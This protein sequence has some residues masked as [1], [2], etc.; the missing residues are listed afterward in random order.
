MSTAQDLTALGLLAD[1]ERDYAE[2]DKKWSE[3][4]AERSRVK[5]AIAVIREKVA[6]FPVNEPAAQI[7]QAKPEASGPAEIPPDAFA[8]MKIREAARKYMEM[9][10]KPVR[11]AKLARALNKGG[12][13]NKTKN[14]ESTVFSSLRRSVLKGE[15]FAKIGMDFGLREWY[16]DE[17]LAEFDREAAPKSKD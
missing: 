5:S 10:E 12:M 17:Q 8:G 15:D 13:E 7:P 2:I 3:L 9:T 16:T 11:A 6:A 1:L 4:G 14:F